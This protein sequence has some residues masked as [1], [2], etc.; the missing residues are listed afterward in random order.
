MRA[1]CL[2]IAGSVVLAA[3]AAGQPRPSGAATRSAAAAA[4]VN[5]AE[6]IA[7]ARAD[8][9]A[10][11]RAT[12]TVA[13]KDPTK[14]LRLFDGSGREI[15][16]TEAPDGSIKADVNPQQG[17]LIAP[18]TPERTPLTNQGVNLPAR[19]L[20]FTPAGATNLGGLFLRPT[21]IPLTW[22][23]QLRAYATELLVGYEFEDGGERKLAVPKTVN[24]FAE[25]AN[26]RIVES[27]VTITD[28]GSSGFKRVVLSTGEI[29]GETHFTARAGPVDELK[30]S[31]T[32]Q[33]EVG[34]LKLTVYPAELPAFG[35]GSGTLTVTLLARDGN[36]LP[37]AR[38]LEVQLTSRRLLHPA[39]LTIDQGKNSATADIRT[40]GYGHDEVL[41][42]SGD[43]Q[44]PFPVDLVFPLAATVAAAVG[45]SLGGVARYLRNR[46]KRAPLLVRRILEGT[47]VGVIVVGAAWVGLVRVE[48][49]TGILGTPFGAF[50]LAALAGY[51]GCVV[52]D[53][54]AGKTFGTSKPT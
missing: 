8:R 52:L 7:S 27:S 26:A 53:H 30:S 22:N 42:Q 24:F 45:G 9:V 21:V 6:N 49:S 33:R 25:G 18:P 37:A 10:P 12:L 19:Y 28:S 44:A 48:V 50:V 31:V 2:C 36:P 15:A 3:P 54:I 17:Y 35:V 46:R 43:F 51:L 38:P 41:A 47:I 13:R 5:I 4:R 34:R 29:E 32:V 1:G 11:N 23:D 39:T 16:T 20:T 14:K 40:T